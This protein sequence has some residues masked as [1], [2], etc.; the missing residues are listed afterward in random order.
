MFV[1]PLVFADDF[2]DQTQMSIHALS[3]D[4][5]IFKRIDI[6]EL[7]ILQPYDEDCINILI[8]CPGHQ[9][10]FHQLFKSVRTYISHSFL[11][12]NYNK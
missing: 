8:D 4:P 9:T 3:C 6:F 12:S 5:N 10:V 7:H 2:Y 1:N 11:R